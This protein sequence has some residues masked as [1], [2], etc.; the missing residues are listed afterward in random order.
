MRLE[1]RESLVTVLSTKDPVVVA[2]AK[3][4]LDG[5]GILYLAWGDTANAL[6]G[7]ALVGFN[8]SASLVKIQVRQSVAEDACELLKDL[9]APNS[10]DGT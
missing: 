3:S 4:I 2:I 6:F 5:A 8:A 1:D 7:G 9:S 10:Q